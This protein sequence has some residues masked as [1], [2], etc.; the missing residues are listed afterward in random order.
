MRTEQFFQWLLNNGYG[1]STSKTRLSNCIRVSEYE[2]DLDS[3]FRRDRCKGLLQKLVYSNQDKMLNISPKHNIP[4]NGDIYNGTATLKQAVRLYI[5]F[6]EDFNKTEDEEHKSHAGIKYT[7]TKTIDDK[8][9]VRDSYDR[10]LSH[11]NISKEDLYEFG[12]N[13]TIFPPYDKVETYWSDLKNRIFNNGKVYIRGYGRDA[14]GTELFLGLYEH[15]F[16]NT[17]IHKDP[18][19]N[20]IPQKL[21]H[22][23]TGYKRNKDLVNYQVSHIFGKTKNVLMFE[24]PWNIV[25]VPKLI[26]PFTGHEA[27]GKWPEEYQKIFLTIVKSKYKFFIEEFNEIIEILSFSERINEYCESLKVKKG[28]SKVIEQFQRDALMEFKYIE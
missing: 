14:K 3:H 18:T 15:L 11:L 23:L 9:A 21:I 28:H 22:K 27:K 10:F 4:I 7:Q 20:L 12:L 26:D 13:E 2:G 5:N 8:L 19:N 24:A 6:C 16:N 25:F 17:N 1:A